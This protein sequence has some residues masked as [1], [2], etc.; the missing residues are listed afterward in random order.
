MR[1]GVRALSKKPGFTAIAILSLALG[2]GANTSIFSIVNSALLKPLPVEK[3]DELVYVFGG[4]RNNPYSVCAYPEYIDYRDNNQVFSGLMAYG[5]ISVSFGSDERTELINGQIVSGNYFDLLGVRASIGRTFLPEEDQAPN[6][7]PVLVISHKLWQQ[8][9]GGQSN[10]LG[11]QVNLNGRSFTIIGITPAG[12]N[13]AQALETNDIYVPMMMQQVVRPPR[14]G[15]SG[16]MNAD[17]L[18]RRGNRW[19]QIVGRLKDD[20]TIEQAQ[21]EISTIAAS[22]EQAYPDTQKDRIAT[23]FPVSKI[24]PVGYPQLIT[25]ATLLLSVVGIVLVIAC[26]NVANLLL[27]RAT[28]RRKEIAI[29]L[30]L[31]ARR[32]RLIR[33]L[34]TESTMLSLAGGAM[35]L[36]LASWVV[37]VLKTTP[38]PA[39]MFAFTLDYSL[40][41]RVLGFTFVLSLITGIL[42]G[43]AP[44][45]QASR[46]DLVTSLKDESFIPEQSYRR[47]N[48]RNLLVIAQVAL[49]LVLLVS[50]GLFLRSLRHTQGV[51]PGFDS[52]KIL[53][54]TLNINL[55]RYTREQ[56]QSFYQQ[57]IERMKA[58]PGVESATLSRT[59][60]M[61]GAGRTNSL[62][63]EGRQT[64]DNVFRNE[65][66]GDDNNSPLIVRTNVVAL[67][68]FNTMGIGM[69]S[70]RDF[71]QQDREGSPRVVIVNEAFIR[72]HFPKDEALGKR[73]SFNGQQ[74][75]WLEIVGVVR[76]SKYRSLSERP[77]PFTYVP[78]GQ[79]H[80]TGM[81]LF[82]RSAGDPNSLAGAVRNEIQSMDR[83]L[84]VT[85]LQSM[86]VLI[87][88]SLF[89]A[90]MGAV[91][92]GAF[93]LLAL[94]LATVGLY[95]VMAYS[96][97][98]RTRELGIR[99]AL[100]ANRKDVIRLVI[101]QGMKL[102]LI[103]VG[104]GIA[105][106]LAVTR[107]LS[108]LL[109]E[110]S[111]SDPVTY[112]LISLLLAL[113]ALIACYIPARR[114]TRVDP[115][116]ALRYE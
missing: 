63:L 19:L 42:F 111:A 95:G 16:E 31:G 51:D 90:K 82:V 27:A 98:R 68:Y 13:G 103:G 18:S 21:S 83:N 52:D 3:P 93:G 34:L 48:L 15:F 22:I 109:F 28:S 23:L 6:T 59:V 58:L 75:P 107:L 17:L 116:V 92:L 8:R 29:R 114:A 79:N 89:P 73:L 74:G 78:L 53:T 49:S 100:G 54:A 69:L 1:Y 106:S 55:L 67:D 39:G 45:L 57:V 10:I 44:A 35:G 11:Q 80:E 41:Y 7:H 110:V 14:A 43:L 86:T 2:I 61:T 87:G 91:L 104:I 60:P 113:V 97:S 102:S 66:A 40:D 50:A 32:S 99:M 36:L 56:G 33:Q 9:F 26:A 70:G 85:G 88:D 101:S 5:S 37:D 24:D 115:L 105:I 72:T 112:L 30:A 77:V 94:L 20:V 108:S 25:V 12:F 81:T 62:T 38:P 46:P 84:P 65:G 76:D 47:F 71:N 4:T 96:V 64:S